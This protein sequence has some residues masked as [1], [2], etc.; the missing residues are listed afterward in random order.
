MEV[1]S[2]ITNALPDVEPENLNAHLHPAI[3]AALPDT[4][5]VQRDVDIHPA[6][7]NAEPIQEDE[8]RAVQATPS[9]AVTES[10][11]SSFTMPAMISILTTPART[12]TTPPSPPK[13]SLR[14]EDDVNIDAH[15]NPL[16]SE[17]EP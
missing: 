1:H 7:E 10:T 13:P 16:F 4:E 9:S 15:Y 11:T 5:P 3:I 6:I 14:T 17:Y 2:A 12:T 8:S